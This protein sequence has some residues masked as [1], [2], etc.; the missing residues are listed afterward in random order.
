MTSVR[1]EEGT[2]AIATHIIPA[3]G[4]GIYRVSPRFGGG[5]GLKL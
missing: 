2:E 1:T 5:S 3:F 4:A